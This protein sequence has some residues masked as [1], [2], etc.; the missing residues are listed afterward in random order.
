MDTPLAYHVLNFRMP[1][2][3]RSYKLC[4]H[5][6]KTRVV[7]CCY[8]CPIMTSKEAEVNQRKGHRAYVTRMMNAA[9]NLVR[10]FHHAEQ[11][12]LLSLRQSL[13]EKL[14]ILKGLD[15]EILGDMTEEGEIEVEIVRSSEHRTK[16]AT[17]YNAN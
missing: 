17:T 10:Y 15:E 16:Y 12:R 11:S 4:S 13:V 2:G 8:C 9:M 3:L 14:D 7:C 5:K 1:E 6:K